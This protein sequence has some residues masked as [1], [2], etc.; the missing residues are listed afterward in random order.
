VQLRNCGE[1]CILDTNEIVASAFRDLKK[2]NE[3]LDRADREHLTNVIADIFDD[4]ITVNMYW[5]KTGTHPDADRYL[6]KLEK[7]IKKHPRSYELIEDIRDKIDELLMNVVRLPTW[8]E[9]HV[10][11]RGS[12]IQLELGQDYRITDWMKTHAKEYR[13][14]AEIRDW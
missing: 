6:D 2:H 12:N 7:L 13:I 1:I 4:H 14:A 8:H 11:I 9:I 5:T 10:R 3:H